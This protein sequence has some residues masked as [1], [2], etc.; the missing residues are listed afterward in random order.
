MLVFK[1]LLGVVFG[2]LVLDILLFGFIVGFYLYAE[3]K[4]KR[5]EAEE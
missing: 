3:W 5:E 1:I 2:I 4:N